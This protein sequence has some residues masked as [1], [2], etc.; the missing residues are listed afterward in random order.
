[1]NKPKI[2]VEIPALPWLS[3]LNES[4]KLPPCVGASWKIFNFQCLNKLLG[5]GGKESPFP[6]KP[7]QGLVL[8]KLMS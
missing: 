3:F 7:V 5:S 4:P 8:A 6:L 2:V 1:M